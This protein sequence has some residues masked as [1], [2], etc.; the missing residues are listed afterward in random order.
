MIIG[1]LIPAGTG[2]LRY[3]DIRLEAPEDDFDR[4]IGT[5]QPAKDLSEGVTEDEIVSSEEL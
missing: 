3:R 2:M 4:L 5:E 1:H